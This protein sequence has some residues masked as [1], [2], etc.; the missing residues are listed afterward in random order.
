MEGDKVK[1]LNAAL[2]KRALG[3]R[4]RDTVEEYVVEKEGGERLQRRK[5]TSK[6]VPADLKAIMIALDELRSEGDFAGMSDEELRNLK[7]RYLAELGQIT[8][9][10]VEIMRDGSG[11][12]IR[13]KA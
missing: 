10:R 13:L 4:S 8:G 3:Y 9:G 11:V 6:E 7:N 12:R 1:K 2:M 5:V